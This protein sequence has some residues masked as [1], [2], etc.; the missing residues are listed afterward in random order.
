MKDLK[1]WGL[2]PDGLG[3]KRPIY[4]LSDKEKTM[5]SVSLCRVVP[6]VI[7]VALALAAIGCNTAQL[8]E[9]EA[10]RRHRRAH[11]INQSELIADI[12]R[13]MP[14]DEPS[15]L[16]RQAHTSIRVSDCVVFA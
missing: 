6:A 5:K 7:L 14:F 8:G 3:P 9:T 2:P 12:D 13:V 15:R 16:Y 11:R 1:L 4:W 10:G